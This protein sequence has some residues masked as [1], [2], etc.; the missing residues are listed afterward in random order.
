MGMGSIFQAITDFFE[1][2]F[3]HSSPEVQKK[4]LIKKLDQDC[5][6]ITPSLY[7]K[8]NL[9]GN[10][11]EAIYILY[12][13]TRPLDNLFAQTVSPLDI[14]RQHRFEAQLF[15]T[16]Y[17]ID[18][19]KAIEELSFE[20]RKADVL[21]SGLNPE[22]IYIHQHQVMDRLLKELNNNVFKKMDIDILYLRQV[23]EF[24]HY[25]LITFL[26]VFDNNFIPADLTYKP[27]YREVPLKKAFSLLE[28][29]YYQMNSLKITTAVGDAVLALAKLRKG[30]ELFEAEK[31]EYLGNLMKINYIKNQVLQP[32]KLKTLIRLCKEDAAYEPDFAKYSGSP[33]QEFSEMMQQKFRADEERIKSEIQD[34]VI[35]E[36]L[37]QLF[38]G[39]TLEETGNY[40]QKYNVLLQTESTLSFKWILPLRILKTFVKVYLSEPIKALLTNISIEGFFNNPSYKTHFSSIIYSVTNADNEFEKFENSFDKNQRNSI[41]VLEGYIRD[42]KKDKDFY[43]KLEK[44]VQSIDNEAHNLLQSLVTVLFSL[45]NELGDLIADSKKPSSELISNLK[46]LMLSSR[47][48]DSTS[49]LESQYGT[50]HIFFEIMKNY[51]IINSG[52]LQNE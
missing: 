9:Q 27:R 36:E 17:S 28:D 47:N 34:E 23:V 18:D 51:V 35:S 10:F 52:E 29:L 4:K 20:Q 50:W 21:N 37:I 39:M 43:N 44:M 41:R 45:Y 13:N 19:Q 25:N 40:S 24:C 31:K 2:I 22:R 6:D 33:K 14:Q 46:V 12:K 16:G 48:R 15:I 5:E 7:K 49:L 32:D 1:S 26:Q 38:P 30:R 8:G 42:S 3:K 11:A